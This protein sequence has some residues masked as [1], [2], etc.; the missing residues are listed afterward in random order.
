MKLLEKIIHQVK[1][2][3]GRK[4]KDK[5]DRTLMTRKFYSPNSLETVQLPFLS[6]LNV[7]M[8]YPE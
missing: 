1:K 4:R 3:G 2:K 5:D 7:N 6:K 8:Y